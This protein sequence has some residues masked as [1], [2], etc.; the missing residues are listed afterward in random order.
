MLDG[1]YPQVQRTR[2]ASFF[3]LGQSLCRLVARRQGDRRLFGYRLLNHGRKHP[4]ML[5]EL[6]EQFAFPGIGRQIP[7][8]LA[9]GDRS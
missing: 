7:D 8:D 9:F 6:S 4:V 5:G 1:S 3:L 2:P